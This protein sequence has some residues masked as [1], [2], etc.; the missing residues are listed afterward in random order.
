MMKE[1]R[2][3]TSNKMTMEI[4]FFEALP[5]QICFRI[6][7]FIRTISLYIVC[8]FQVNLFRQSFEKNTFPWS[9]Y[10]M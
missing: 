7:Q 2:P 9:F 4:F 5:E 8:K 3:P 10:L 1:D 6:S